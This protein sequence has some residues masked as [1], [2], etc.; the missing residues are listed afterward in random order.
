MSGDMIEKFLR[1]EGLLI[2]LRPHIPVRAHETGEVVFTKR[3]EVLL[4]GRPDRRPSY[5][6]AAGPEQ[7]QHYLEDFSFDKYSFDDCTHFQIEDIF[8]GDFLNASS[9]RIA[10]DFMR[11]LGTNDGRTFIEVCQNWERSLANAFNGEACSIPGPGGAEFNPYLSAWGRFNERD[12]V[13]RHYAARDSIF[14]SGPD[15]GA[16]GGQFASGYDLEVVELMLHWLGTKNGREFI[17]GCLDNIR[18][19]TEREFAPDYQSAGVA[20]DVLKPEI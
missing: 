8:Q 12:P 19:K 6:L 14:P 2:D 3:F 15:G 9:T 7:G 11:W 10:M 13:S 18:I 5:Y 16:M 1:D 20:P 17:D 4:V